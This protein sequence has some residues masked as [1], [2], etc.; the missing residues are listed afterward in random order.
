[1][2][3]N[4]PINISEAT[5]Q[6]LQEIV[7]E[8]SDQKKTLVSF[9]SEQQNTKDKEHD[10][11]KQ[12]MQEL[13]GQVNQ[14]RLEKSTHEPTEEDTASDNSLDSQSSVSTVVP[15][16]GRSSDTEDMSLYEPEHLDLL[17]R[18]QRKTI[19]GL[20]IE[21]YELKKELSTCRSDVS[22]FSRN[23]SF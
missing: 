22:D 11:L 15:T 10:E 9:I 13:I 23:V 16:S 7:R 12:K 2:T 8:L 18:K 19:E 6:L 17:H 3:E 1:M 5:M 21:N 14:L 4:E 20:K